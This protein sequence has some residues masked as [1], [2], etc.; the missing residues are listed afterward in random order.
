MCREVL[1]K[2]CFQG[3]WGPE[4]D[5]SSILWHLQSRFWHG[6]MRG[7]GNLF[8]HGKSCFYV[9]D[10]KYF[11]ISDYFSF[12]ASLMD[13]LG[14]DK[15]FIPYGMEEVG[16]F[17]VPSNFPNGHSR[18]LLILT[19]ALYSFLHFLFYLLSVKTPRSTISPNT[20][21]FMHTNIF[22]EGKTFKSFIIT[23]FKQFI[24]YHLPPN[25]EYQTEW[26][27]TP[28]YLISSTRHFNALGPSDLFPERKGKSKD[29]EKCDRNSFSRSAV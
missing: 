16:L 28:R 18:R 3:F 23:C 10:I 21:H 12:S 7:R 25:S 24:G 5:K 2:P 26:A 8:F 1:W 29:A 9:S 22:S 6:L 11:R 20:Q 13:N 4:V 19:Y 15:N 14:I 27:T 17:L